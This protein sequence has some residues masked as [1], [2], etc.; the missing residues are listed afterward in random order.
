AQP[1][2]QRVQLGHR[3]REGRERRDRRALRQRGLARRLLLLRGGRRPAVRA[4]GER[5]QQQQRGGLHRAPPFLAGCTSTITRPGTS[6]LRAVCSTDCAV[7]ASY[8][9]RSLATELAS[10]KYIT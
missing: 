2:A 7:A 9:P 1:V 4:A 10:P 6:T 3:R 8:R 5:E